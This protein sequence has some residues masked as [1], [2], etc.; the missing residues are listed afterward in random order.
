MKKWIHFLW[1][2][3]FQL[4]SL[5]LVLESDTG[6]RKITFRTSRTWA[7]PISFKFQGLHFNTVDAR[8]T[9]L[10]SLS[11]CA[12]S[13]SFL[14]THTQVKHT[15][16]VWLTGWSS[17]RGS[18]GSSVDPPTTVRR[19]CR[20]WRRRRSKAAARCLASVVCQAA[21]SPVYAYLCVSRSQAI[22]T[23]LSQA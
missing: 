3:L 4:L 19:W 7:I 13:T 2:I 10:S 21:G 15:L 11:I 1:L 8:V 17:P 14:F 18:S 22:S 20:R 16:H 6:A 9:P 5:L 23:W 12:P